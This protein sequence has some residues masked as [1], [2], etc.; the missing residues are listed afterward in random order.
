MTRLMPSEFAGQPTGLDELKRWKG[1]ELKTF[2]LYV[3]PIVLK[4]ILR[5]EKY[6]HFLSLSVSIRILL[7]I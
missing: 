4:V 3:G 1:T 6:V 5:P 2:L 7:D